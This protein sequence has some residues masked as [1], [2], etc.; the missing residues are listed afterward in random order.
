VGWPRT[1]KGHDA[2]WVVVDCLTKSAHFLAVKNGLQHG[3]MA[4]LYLKEIVRLHGIPLSIVLDRD[5][6]FVFKFWQGFQSIMGTKLCI[7]TTFHPQSDD[8][9]ERT[10]QKLED[11]L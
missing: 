11:M 7:S 6:R 8:Q 5:T 4:D 10:I 1:Q 9:S 3:Q 2:I